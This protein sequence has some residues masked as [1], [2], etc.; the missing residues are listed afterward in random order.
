MALSDFIDE[1][2]LEQ[3][4]EIDILENKPPDI[5]PSCKQSG[6]H[7]RGKEWRCTTDRDKCETL[8]WINS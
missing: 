3:D 6:E 2:Q 5:C 1:S 4:Q 8:Y 7:A